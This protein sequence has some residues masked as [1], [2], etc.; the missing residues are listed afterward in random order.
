MRCC[1]RRAS[2]R[3]RD[4]SRRRA[5][6]AVRDPAHASRY[7]GACATDQ[8]CDGNGDDVSAAE[9]VVASGP[10]GNLWVTVNEHSAFG[11][12]GGD[13]SDPYVDRISPSGSGGGNFP[14]SRIN[15]E[16][17]SIVSGVNSDLWFAEFLDRHIG[18]ITTSGV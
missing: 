4:T 12:L 3:C 8:S 11:F 15:F 1:W 14:L 6:S 7:R 5:S 2:L 13:F 18:R 16:I 9:S 10:D 17:R